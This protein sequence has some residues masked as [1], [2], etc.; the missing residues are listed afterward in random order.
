MFNVNALGALRVTEA[1]VPLVMNSASKMIANISSEAG[2]I[3]QNKR[4]SW[5]AYCMSK[6]AL[7][8]GSSLVHNGLKE[9]GGHVLLIHPGWVQTFMRGEL[10]VAAELT[11]T[12]SA[13]KIIGLIR[14]RI[15][16]S[17]G[18]VPAFIDVY[19]NSMPW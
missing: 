15:G 4:S 7:N 19:G 14:E 16:Q 5:F 8:M 12:E 10:D 1:F 11:P 17:P 9:A 6:A 3:G 18:D 2:S 13:G